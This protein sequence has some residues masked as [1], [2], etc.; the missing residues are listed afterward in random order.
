MYG[1]VFQGM[2]YTETVQWKEYLIMANT[3]WAIKSNKYMPLKSAVLHE[4]EMQ[5]ITN[6]FLKIVNA[7]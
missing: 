2:T 3:Q 7:F 4:R 6:A 1:Y 5:K